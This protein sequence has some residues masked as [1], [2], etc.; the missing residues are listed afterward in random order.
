MTLS[1]AMRSAF[2]QLEAI[3]SREQYSQDLV[4]DVL[5]AVTATP[6]GY[7]STVLYDWHQGYSGGFSL[8]GA[9]ETRMA[10]AYSEERNQQLINWAATWGDNPLRKIMVDVELWDMSVPEEAAEAIPYL[11]HMLSMWTE[12]TGREV[13]LYRLIPYSS[14][15]RAT[16]IYDAIAASSVWDLNRQRSFMVDYMLMND[17]NSAQLIDYVDFLVPRCYMMYTD[18]LDE[19]KYFAAYQILEAA[20]ISRGKPVYPIIWFRHHPASGG[21]TEVPKESWIEMVKF[22]SS[23]SATAGT[24]IWGEL[25]TTTTYDW[26]DA[27]DT[28]ISGS[29]DFVLT[30]GTKFNGTSDG[31]SHEP[32]T[33]IGTNDFFVDMFI[34]VDE[35]PSANL[36]I[37]QSRSTGT[38]FN[39][40]IGS[41]TNN[42]EIRVHVAN[43]GTI[44]GNHPTYSGRTLQTGMWTYIH[45]SF[46][47]DGYLNMYIDNPTVVNTARSI[48][49][50][51]SLDLVQTLNPC[52][53]G[54]TN[55]P[56]YMACRVAYMGIGIGSLLT[57]EE[58][59]TIYNNGYGLA[60][61][62]L[63]SGILAKF[64]HRWDL[65]SD[66]TDLIGSV[67]FSPA[68]SS[69]IC[70][71]PSPKYKIYASDYGFKAS[72]STTALQRSLD[73]GA[74][75]VVVDLQPS[76]WITSPLY[77]R[78][79]NQTLICESGVNIV[80]KSGAFT[81]A[82]DSLFSATSKNNISID[83]NNA[84]WSM[85]KTEYPT[86]S[87]FRMGLKLI[88][89]SGVT[90][91]NLTIKDCGGDG[92]YI[93]NALCQNITIRD[94]VCQ[95]NNRNNISVT[96]VDGLLI[97]DVMLI[98]ASGTSPEAGID[99]EPNS[100]TDK[101]SNVVL[102]RVTTENNN[103]CGFYFELGNVT[104]VSGVIDI[105]CEDCVSSGDARVGAPD[106]RGGLWIACNNTDAPSG[107]ILIDSMT[108][109]DTVTQAVTL[110]S[111]T[112]SGPTVELRDCVINNPAALIPTRSPVRFS[113][114]SDDTV[115][116][117]GYILT[118]LQINDSVNRNPIDYY[119]D[120]DPAG[121]TGSISWSDISGNLSLSHSGIVTEYALT[122]LQLQQWI[123]TYTTSLLSYIDGSDMKYING[124]NIRR[125]YG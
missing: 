24:W 2:K 1:P 25:Y 37:Y 117:G 87:E 80:A 74:R 11:Q 5:A 55:T 6:T 121:Q 104:S 125:V 30:E 72:D 58:R 85:N 32:I 81:V 123:S 68:P 83:G 67:D 70:D 79:D 92:I 90:V 29:E 96:D 107:N 34:Q 118:N 73:S 44:V 45:L 43:S 46:D 13:G 101:I 97:E 60:T 22:C 78:T 95:N 23:L 100:A 62:S 15:T 106:G 102:R 110:R 77:F 111:K 19:W 7:N 56:A 84:I 41:E 12:Q 64:D 122:T 93:G 105:L 42:E 88:G 17:R 8:P 113:A 65:G 115:D 47:R 108:I 99:F 66:I 48:T 124:Q 89:C 53:L 26:K 40:Q 57:D 14:I 3:Y 75:R 10:D 59:T 49:A 120:T 86:D 82:T 33:D 21:M 61:A 36:P 28:L 20:R 35:L 39:I 112:P 31:L 71:G 50:W 94:V 52:Y 98:G 91:E 119:D 4:D 38:G 114:A 103:K 9:L 51:T 69:T 27:V 76:G 16:G 63:P 109:N 18:W 116:N 54:R